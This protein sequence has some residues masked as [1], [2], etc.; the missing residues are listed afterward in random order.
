MMIGV[1]IP[2]VINSCGGY[3]DIGLLHWPGIQGVGVKP[4]D[5]R[6]EQK[7]HEYYKEL[8]QIHKQGLIHEIG[9]SNFTAK[10]LEKL[11]KNCEIKPKYNSMELHP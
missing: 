8:E 4:D 2:R 11:L 3:I 1:D 9:V 10:H 6:H 7:R 5:P